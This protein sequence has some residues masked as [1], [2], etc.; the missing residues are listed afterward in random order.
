[1]TKR[2][3]LPAF[4]LVGL[5]LGSAAQAEAGLLNGL[6]GHG[7][8]CCA[9]E[10]SCC[11][12]AEPAC[13]A[14]AEPACCEPEP[15]CCAPEPACCEPAPRCCRPRHLH[16]VKCFLHRLFHHHRCCKPAC[17]PACCEP[18]PACAAPEPAC[19]H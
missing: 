11:A 8:G 5:V 4:V 1:M 18:E 14:P 15:A 3:V 10:P 2:F 19:C 17:E 6:L 12:P 7:H 16:K 9:P 13:C